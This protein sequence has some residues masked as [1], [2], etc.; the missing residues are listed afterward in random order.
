MTIVFSKNIHSIK[1]NISQNL[2]EYLKTVSKQKK[3]LGLI[4]NIFSEYLSLYMQIFA[5]IFVKYCE[6]S[7][8]ATLLET[9]SK[10][11]K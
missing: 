10:V 4:H 6:Y 9:K 1:F 3:I 7:G 11:L 8:T 5:Q 2:E